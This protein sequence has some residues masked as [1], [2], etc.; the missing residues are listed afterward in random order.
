MKPKHQKAFSLIELMISLIVISIVTAAFT[1]IL[2]KKLKSADLSLSSSVEYNYDEAFCSSITQN[3]SVCTG[4]SCEKCASGYYLDDNGACVE[5]GVQNC[6]R[7]VDSSTCSECKDGYYYD[8]TS[9]KCVQCMTGCK[10]CDKTQCL[11]C[12]DNCEIC[13]KD[14]GCVKCNQGFYWTGTSCQNC[15]Y[16]QSIWEV[17]SSLKMYRYNMGDECG[18]TI[19]PSVKICYANEPCTVDTVNGTC[20]RATAENPTGD[21]SRMQAGV[22]YIT[23]SYDASYRTVCNWYAANLGCTGSTHLLSKSELDKV[24]NT[25]PSSLQDGLLLAHGGDFSSTY[26][27]NPA[28]RKYCFGANNNH[29]YPYDYWGGNS[30]DSQSYDETLIAKGN[31]TSFVLLDR[32]TSASVRCAMGFKPCSDYYFQN[33]SGVCE[34]CP[35]HCKTCSSATVCTTCEDSYFKASNNACFKYTCNSNF[36]FITQ[37]DDKVVSLYRY[38]LGDNNFEITSAMGISIC[39]ANAACNVDFNKPVCIKANASYSG[40]T[41]LPS[42]CSYMGSASYSPCRRT[43]CNWYA[44]NAALSQLSGWH[45]LNDTELYDLRYLR[46]EWYNTNA[47]I[48]SDPICMGDTIGNNLGVFASCPLYHIPLGGV[49]ETSNPYVFWGQSYSTSAAI[50]RTVYDPYPVLRTYPKAGFFQSVIFAK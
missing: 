3:C 22:S 4:S 12:V 33:S 25:W 27:F 40:F 36:C 7:C 11:A 21:V 2:S 30:S 8:T 29:C 47:S 26:I 42:E 6:S 18:P 28:T 35:N 34:K 19:P 48:P 31:H 32:K 10:K 15:S 14:K 17:D 16:S 20:W 49:F 23:T 46:D 43:V 5:C 41:A 38:S 45:W 39:Y 50:F 9:K 44:A 13:T 24:V 37:P 1:P